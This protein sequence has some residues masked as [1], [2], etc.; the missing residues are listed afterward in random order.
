MSAR[1][2]LVSNAS[3]GLTDL[4]DS[5]DSQDSSTV[6]ALEDR[7]RDASDRGI[8]VRVISAF[9]KH[10]TRRGR[11]KL[12]KEILEIPEDTLKDRL[13]QLKVCKHS[14]SDDKRPNKNQTEDPKKHDR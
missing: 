12:L 5:Q 3:S 13:G 10:I 2:Q 9:V 7:L 14:G 8:D 4:P 1:P 11:E 6:I